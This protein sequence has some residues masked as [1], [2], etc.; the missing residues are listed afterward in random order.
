MGNKEKKDLD[1]LAIDEEIDHSSQR[2][3][4]DANC[5]REFIICNAALSTVKVFASERSLEMYKAFKRLSKNDPGFRSA[6]EFQNN[7]KGLPLLIC[8]RG[9][10]FALSDVKHFSVYECLASPEASDRLYDKADDSKVGQVMKR[11]YISY[12][13]YCLN[14]WGNEVIVFLHNRLPIVDFKLNE[15]KFRFVRSPRPIITPEHFVYELYLLAPE[16]VS[17]VDEM[18]ADHKVNKNNPLLGSK[19]KNM[20]TFQWSSDR[21]KFTSSVKWGKFE[22]LDSYTFSRTRRASKLTLFTNPM[23]DLDCNKSVE[24]ES[25]SLL[26]VTL[27]L[28]YYEDDFE[29]K[30]QASRSGGGG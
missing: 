21:S 29:A 9:F 10:H 12:A 26:A 1:W 5:L 18:T 14:I 19:L 25:L 28:K 16:Q 22:Y 2:T 17:L 8:K 3:A 4:S 7:S 24:I 20:L 13:R 6:K 15:K 30:L 27:I 11:T 23:V